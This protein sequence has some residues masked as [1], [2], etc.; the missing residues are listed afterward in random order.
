MSVGGL[1]GEPLSMIESSPGATT[2]L[3]QSPSDFGVRRASGAFRRDG[4]AS[5]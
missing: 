5:Y 2:G 3:R 4:S 1:D